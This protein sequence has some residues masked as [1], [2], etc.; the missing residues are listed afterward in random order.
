M[1]SGRK[2][3]P[4]LV[5]SRFA[6]SQLL[7]SAEIFFSAK[8]SHLT[9]RTQDKA[10]SEPIVDLINALRNCGLMQPRRYKLSPIPAKVS[11]VNERDD[12]WVNAMCEKHPLACMEQRI[13]LSVP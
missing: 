6:L 8:Q 4:Y 13:V 3:V 2:H 12:K 11:Q 1:D 7:T 5:S 10:H 9:H